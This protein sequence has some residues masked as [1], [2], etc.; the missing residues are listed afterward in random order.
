[1]NE[2]YDKLM[3]TSSPHIKTSFDTRKTMMMVLAALLPCLVMGTYVF[4]I[5]VLILTAVC[6]ISAVFFEW[7]YEKLLHKESTIND[8]SAVVTG[9]ILAF[10]LPASFPLWMA[11]IGTFVAIVIVKQLYGGLGKNIAN[12]AIVGRIVLLL[13]FTN[14]MTTWPLT[15]LVEVSKETAAEGVDA[16]TGPTPLGVLADGGELPDILRMFLGFT[17]GSAGEVSA[18]AILIGG[19]FLIWKRVISPVIPGFFIATMFIFAFIYYAATGGGPGGESALHMALFHIFAGGAMFGAFF[20][21]T[22]YVSSPIMTRARV[23]YAI[24]CGV[25]TMVIRLW[26]GYPEGVS[27]AILF[28]NVMSPLLD[29]VAIKTFYKDAGGVKKDGK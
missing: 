6:V 24:G 7:G 2:Y 12:P 26:A 13:S 14:E 10:N 22:D 20:C 4:G 17:G 29:R 5:N 25:I 21:A 28:M 16:L 18:V 27:F 19:A 1:M 9:A 11:V 3:V 23:V 15:K 8:L